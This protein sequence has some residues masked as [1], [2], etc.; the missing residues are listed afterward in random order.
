MLGSGRFSPTT[1]ASDVRGVEFRRDRQFLPAALE[2]LETPSSPTRRALLL[3]LCTFVVL[4]LTWG[5][6]G[7]IDIEAVAKGKVQPSGR[8]K[9]IQP[10]EPGRVSAI[11]V[12]DG[13]V[14]K[15]GD[16]LIEL[17]PM[18]TRADENVATQGLAVDL[19]DAARYRS[20]ID[21]VDLA[22][23]RVDTNPAMTWPPS[24]PRELQAREQQALVADLVNL[25]GALQNLDMQIAER[26]STISRLD[27]S[28][29]ADGKLAATLQQHADM[30]ETLQAHGT[31]TKADFLAALQDL[32]RAQA[33]LVADQGQRGEAEAAIATLLS[34]KEKALG[35]F[36]SDSANKFEDA[37]NKAV[38]D[39]EAADKAHARLQRTVMMSPVDGVVQKSAV[40]SIGQV[41]STG[42]ELMVVVPQGG[43]LNIEAF[44]DN[45]DIAFVKAGQDVAIKLDSLPFTRY[46]TIRGKVIGVATDAIDEEEARRM[47]ANATSLANSS[48]MG[49]SSQSQKFVFP[50]IISLDRSS[51]QVGEAVIP[52]SPGMSVTAEIKTDNQRIIDYVL[53]PLTQMASEAL[54][55]R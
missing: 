16:R 23:A 1:W 8:V 35:Q 9:V 7:R 29:E 5:L 10:F 26:R 15:K 6:I 14:V 34:E 55:E 49:S 19:A 25:S 44:I 41:V 20:A 52:L 43:T 21:A 17:D 39:G 47:Q 11:L 4:S 2:V 42:Q 18:E 36:R 37:S 40:T 48:S 33:T 3:T 38:V 45:I 32:Q 46:G 54:H 28:L 30:R 22:H 24:I 51:V 50:I 27:R 12:D 53:S 31:G 13:A